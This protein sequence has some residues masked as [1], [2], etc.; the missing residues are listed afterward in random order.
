MVPGPRRELSA[1]GNV[2]EQGLRAL[3]VDDHRVFAEAL[4]AGLEPDPRF[5]SVDVAFSDGG[6]QA[7][8]STRCVDLLL[9]D[10]NLGSHSGLDLLD[11]V[12]SA[13][14][15]VVVV[16]VSGLDDVDEVIFAL[17][18]GA[19]A[20]V[21]KGTSVDGLL[22]AIDEAVAGR[23]WLP[24]T[25]LGPVL[26]SLIS[27]EFQRERAPSFVDSLT[28]RQFEVLEFLAEGL[29]RSQIAARLVISPNTVRTHVQDILRKANVHSTLAALALAR[30]DGY[31]SAASPPEISAPVRSV[32]S[33]VRTRC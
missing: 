5:A 25:L 18:R 28:P 15:H 32:R 13:M 21:P 33:S 1:A 3:V 9:L 6:A 31:L 2:T 23:T 26:Q 8:L 12:R 24:P 19:R 20:W 29:S 16:V 10:V 22:T 7:I 4:A 30:E 27:H 11:R 17:S 14:P